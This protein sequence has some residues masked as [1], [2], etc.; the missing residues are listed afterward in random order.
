M[1]A[2]AKIESYVMA[3][4][5]WNTAIT[6]GML[7]QRAHVHANTRLTLAAPWLQLIL[8]SC[9]R[10][11]AKPPSS[12][13]S[14]DLNGTET[15]YKTLFPDNLPYFIIAEMGITTKFQENFAFTLPEYSDAGLTLV[16]NTRLVKPVQDTR[17][18][19]KQLISNERVCAAPRALPR[20]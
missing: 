11:H 3:D 8:Y 16:V 2:T 19:V 6:M 13:A 12:N 17:A 1:A 5:D 20:V 4:V 9:A 14:E 15:N 10:V 18:L 7:I